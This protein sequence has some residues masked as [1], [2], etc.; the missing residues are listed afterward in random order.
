M[1]IDSHCHLNHLKNELI[2]DEV[3]SSAKDNNVNVILNIST[4]KSEFEEIIEISQIYEQVYFSLG[5]HPHEAHEMC[6]EIA[7]FIYNNKK[8]KKLI[9]IGETGLDFFYNH[10]QKHI[11]IASFEHQI[12]IAQDLSIPIIIHMRDAENETLEAIRR[13]SKEKNFTGV[14]HCFTG[15]KKF[16]DEIIELGF[17]ISASGI[18]TFKKSEELR[19]IFSNVPD[20]NLLVETDSPYLSPEPKR[21]KINQPSNIIHTV[22]KLAEIRNSSIKHIANITNNN[23]RKLFNRIELS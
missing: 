16:A 13:K 2:L 12:E 23:F 14:I 10:S 19:N 11:Q 17:Y 4:K 5:I 1:I 15:S 20:D 3:V 8:N 21:G 6:N 7:E 18:I 22:S 9:G